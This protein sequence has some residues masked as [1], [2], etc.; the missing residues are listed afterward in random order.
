MNSHKWWVFRQDWMVSH[1]AFTIS[2]KG[3]FTVPIPTG[4][5]HVCLGFDWEVCLV[6]NSLWNLL[7]VSS[8]FIDQVSI[9]HKF[10][11]RKLF[12]QA[13][14]STCNFVLSVWSMNVE[15]R[16]N[17]TV[18]AKEIIKYLCASLYQD[19]VPCCSQCCVFKCSAVICTPIKT[20][21]TTDCQWSLM[22]KHWS[23]RVP[24][25]HYQNVCVHLLPRH[26]SLH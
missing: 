16:T 18:K 10:V 1:E 15:E 12:C 13:H 8:P 19:Q 11:Q 4:T 3:T 25:W 23:W 22:R 7:S 17:V 6:V 20:P 21:C 14:L 9:L 26:M 5:K 2:L 24:F